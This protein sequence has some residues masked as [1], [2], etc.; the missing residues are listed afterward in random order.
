MHN[1]NTVGKDF[2]FEF[3]DLDY[4]QYAFSFKSCFG[5]FASFVGP[6][7]GYYIYNMAGKSYTISLVYVTCFHGVA[8]VLFI[9]IFYLD[10]TE[11]EIE[12]KLLLRK[13][14]EKAEFEEEAQ[15]VEQKE[16][17][18]KLVKKKYS[19]WQVFK[20]CMSDAELRGLILVYLIANGVF[21]T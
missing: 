8:I 16:E 12:K 1:L 6:Y 20:E 18:V 9:L 19:L 5:I 2:I 11:G 4:R 13:S 17:E 15:L 3:A 14:L 21:K 10:F 7:I